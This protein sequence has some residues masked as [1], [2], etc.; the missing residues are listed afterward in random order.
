MSA[1]LRDPLSEPELYEHVK[2]YQI[3]THSRTYRK[4]KKKDCR[5]NYGRFFL[6]RT[7]VTKPLPQSLDLPEK[8][9]TVPWRE[10]ILTKVKNALMNICTLQKIM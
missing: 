3:H 2:A 6:A 7:T 9:Q 10:S 5:F 1:K 4:Y 8:N